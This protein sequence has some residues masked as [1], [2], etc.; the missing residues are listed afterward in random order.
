[1]LE[2][3][4]QVTNARSYIFRLSVSRGGGGGLDGDKEEKPRI[5]EETVS[6]TL[7]ASLSEAPRDTVHARAD[8]A[9]SAATTDQ[10]DEISSLD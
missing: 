6:Q 1:M 7:A 9:Q 2:C 8:G 4:S 10:V 3:G 5:E